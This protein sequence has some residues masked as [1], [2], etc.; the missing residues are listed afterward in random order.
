MRAALFERDGYVIVRGLWP[1][2]EAA[3][4]RDHYM[5]AHARRT[6]PA[7][8]DR[9]PETDVLSRYPRLVHPHRTD[10][11]SRRYVLDARIEA[12]LGELF[13]EAPLAIQSMLFYKPPGG[14]GFGL[15]QDQPGVCASPR[16]CIGCWIALD[17]ADA[18]NGGMLVVP[19]SQRLGLVHG[20]PEPSVEFLGGSGLRVPDGH[21]VEQTELEPGDALFFSGLVLHGSYA[22][23][24]RDRFRRSFIGH[25]V[26]RSTE[27]LAKFYH[28]PLAFSGE[29]VSCA[30]ASG[31]FAGRD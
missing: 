14:R 19:G 4:L 26:A 20:E 18:E 16:T 8:D 7:Y 28:P 25:Y 24:S 13:G 11:L 17:R 27:S 15:H 22:N 2:E 9:L 12:V 29:E 31:G 10:D 30:V 21:R 6:I 3:A 23:R 5:D 1:R